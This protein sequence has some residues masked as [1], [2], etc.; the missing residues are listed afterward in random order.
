MRILKR[1]LP[2][3]ICSLLAGE[4]A[5][6]HI[7]GGEITYICLG[8]GTYKFTMHIYR[9][10]RD[11]GMPVGQLDPQAPIAIYQ[12]GTLLIDVLHI[13]LLSA[14]NVEAPD[15][16]CLIP[17][18]N[19]CV[20]E[21]IY[22]WEYTFPTWPIKDTYTIEYQRCCRNN[23]IVNIVGPQQA[24]A[25]Y[26]VDIN[27]ASQFNCN[28]SPVFKEFPP[29]VVCVDSDLDFD[30]SAFDTD[31]DSLVY[32]FCLPFKGG[33]FRSDQNN[34]GSCDGPRPDPPCPAPFQRVAFKAPYAVRAPMAGDP[35]VGMDFRTG[36]ITGN[37]QLIG[38]FV[39]GVCVKEYRDGIFLGEIKRDF[40]FNVA[41]CDP[42]VF[43]KVKSDAVVGAKEYVINSC[44][45]NTILF[46]N[47]STLEQF[48]G[49]YKWDFDIRGQS[50]VVN[51]K[52]AEVTFPGIGT[53]RGEMII[54]P[55]L[56]CG[57]T[58]EIFVNLYPSI[59]SDYSFNYDTCIGGPT[60]F[61]DNSTTGANRIESW[62]WDFGEGGT[63]DLQ[64]PTYTY[65]IPGN[66]QVSLTVVDDNACVDVKDVLLPYFPVPPLIV[67]EPSTFVGCSPG[68]LFFNNLS[69]PIDSTYTIEWDFGDG[70]FGFAVSPTHIYEAPGTYSIGVMITS[71]IGCFTSEFFPD[72]ITIKE[73]PQAAFSFSPEEP[74]NFNPSVQF[75]NFSTNHL[76]QQWI[77]DQVGRSNETDPF[78]IFPDTGQYR[79]A[80]IAIHENG[81]RDT[82]IQ[83]LDV[84]PRVTYHMPNAFTPNGDGKNDE[85]RGTGFV[86][87][88]QEF[89]FSIWNRWGEM[90][91][92]TDNPFEA[93]NGGKNNDGQVVAS[94]VYVYQIK[95]LDPRGDKV[96]LQ[97]FAT[98]IK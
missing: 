65:A 49:A 8:N 9:D 11:Q 20:E 40:Q 25:T 28:N 21:G 97:G 19:L 17:P 87:G 29:T 12:N 3:L 10:C 52:D 6:F 4:I 85:F 57:D 61:N 83:Q 56:D 60:A 62:S 31:G 26:F 33:G 81:C 32:S 74:S 63:S 45:N 55:G 70:Q 86:D 39:I 84:I 24:G 7:I 54:N 93:W 35:V 58:A 80:L 22:E 30:H 50:T 18:E 13:T 27:E 72:W 98:L 2:V 90:L 67:V 5:A 69:V 82:V 37:P 14:S 23:T 34:P 94:G 38:Q 96:E 71:P 95:Y 76:N 78:F 68:L 75:T 36:R 92:L 66:H 91:F 59:E 41:D 46:E 1:L 47:E 44:G 89:E 77:F 88:V 16:P 42:T 15:F 43:A 53:Y 51:T 48:I 64:N 73:S 79:V